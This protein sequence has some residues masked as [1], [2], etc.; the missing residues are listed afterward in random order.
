[1]KKRFLVLALVVCLLVTGCLAGCNGKKQASSDA[2]VTLTWIFGGPG[3]LKDSDRVWAEFNEKLK[4]Y[5]P[6]TT[7]EFEVISHDEY[8]ERWKLINA[9]Q[10]DADIVWISWALNFADEVAKGAFMDM[11]D[12]VAQYG[13]D[14]K[15]ELPE[16]LLDLT[17][18]NGRIYGVPCYQM[19]ASPIGFAVDTSHVEKGWL[20]IEEVEKLFN[21]DKTFAKEDYKIIEDYIEKVQS[22]GEK[23]KYISSDFMKRQV[24]ERIGLPYGGLEPITCNAAIVKMGDD[25]KVY[26]TLT[27]FPENYD[28]YDLMSEWYEKGYIRKDIL[29]N[30]T[31]KTGDYLL[32]WTSVFKGTEE[33]LEKTYNKP[34]KPCLTNDYLY[35]GYNASSTNTG[36]SAHSKNP[37]RAMQVINLMNSSKGKELLNLLVYGLEGEHYEKINDEQIN[38]LGES[39]PGASAN[40]YGYQNW[41]LGNTMNTYTTQ[42]DPVGWNKYIDEEINKQ[43]TISRLAGFSLDQTP[44]AKEIAQYQAV[45]KEYEYLDKGTISNYKELISERNEKFKK[46]GSD[47]IVAEVQRQVDEWVKN[48]K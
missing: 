32:S 9:G 12:L 16:W 18:V 11:T 43:A 48:N 1:M 22:S 17:T 7:I 15:A 27:D 45:K 35:V 5:I 14:I 39:A 8:A 20:N 37:E 40:K 30:P 28:Y 47:K 13:Q 3:K 44:I 24:Q 29:E 19:M 23:V 6:N 42:A 4:E 21:T 46:A 25:Y 36:I 41:A 38:W 34:M 33:R 2:E 31:E 10:E 26:D